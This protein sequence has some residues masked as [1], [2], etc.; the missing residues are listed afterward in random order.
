[1]FNALYNFWTNSSTPQSGCG[2]TSV[3]FDIWLLQE[4]MQ[5]GGS[6]AC[7]NFWSCWWTPTPDCRDGFKMQVNH[8]WWQ[9]GGLVEN[10]YCNSLANWPVLLHELQSEFLAPAPDNEP[11]AMRQQSHAQSRCLSLAYHINDTGSTISFFFFFLL[12][13]S[14][15]ENKQA[16]IISTL[17]RCSRMFL[18]SKSHAKWPRNL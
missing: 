4:S 16:W 14:G 9:Q 3:G 7:I 1:M 11:F 5:T 18:L 17:I 10:F 13:L 12:S 8:T 6:H 2:L 15:D